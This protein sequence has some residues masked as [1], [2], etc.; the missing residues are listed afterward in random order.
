MGA[1]VQWRAWA[2]YGVGALVAVQALTVL[3][4]FSVPRKEDTM[5]A[6]NAS[7]AAGVLIQSWHWHSRTQLTTTDL[8][9]MGKFVAPMPIKV[10]AFSVVARAKGGTHAASLFELK[11]GSTVIASQDMVAVAA[12]T[13]ADG[14]VVAAAAD[15]AKG[16]ALQLDFTE[17]GGTTPTL[18]DVSIQV[19]Y[20]AR[21]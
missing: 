15:I 3:F 1:G 12:G 7:P 9:A 5:A 16:A 10:V 19:D 13:V 11:V 18:D 2:A 14:T 21:Y 20:I 6:P 8:V 17:T 4:L